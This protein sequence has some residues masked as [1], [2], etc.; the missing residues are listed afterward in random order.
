[1][2]SLRV[3]GRDQGR[4]VWRGVYEEVVVSGAGHGGV[5]RADGAPG[6]DLVGFEGRGGGD[7]S[8]YV[9]EDG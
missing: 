1:M 6:V 5:R 9:V 8:W 7:G 2:V 4:G 3:L